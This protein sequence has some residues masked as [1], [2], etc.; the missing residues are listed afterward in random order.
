[1]LTAGIIAEYN[2]FHNGH[3]YHIQ[4]TKELH[5]AQRIIVVMSPSFTQRS[6]PAII[7]K[8]ARAKTALLCGADLVLELP[9]PYATASAEY[10][11]KNAVTILNSLGVTNI[12][13][14]GSE[15]G[16]I[17]NLEKA[18]DILD[19]GDFIHLLKAELKKGVSFASARK[20][21]A[22]KLC[23]E[24]E[25]QIFETPNNILAIEYLK[26]LKNL[27]SDITPVTV[28][29]E[30]TAYHENAIQG[31][32]VSATY[33]RKLI[34][35]NS[36]LLK[37]V[38]PEQSLNVLCEEINKG[39]CILS[40][41]SMELSM[42]TKLRTLTEEDIA[43]ISDTGEGLWRRIYKSIRE[44]CSLSEIA[45]LAKTK[46]YTMSRI[47]RILLRGFLGIKA[48]HV[49]TPAAYIRVLGFNDNGRELLRLADKKSALPVITKPSTINRLG[50]FANELFMLES[51]STDIW[52][53]HSEKISK[54]GLD[55][56]TNPV[57]IN[58]VSNYKG[59]CR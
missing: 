42:L 57:Y 16:N 2:P 22:A 54:C 7:S 5:G 33:C 41:S 59:W 10:F 13:S 39:S 45:A 14:F 4:K 32:F 48:Y 28:K 1:M 34:S 31:Q 27:G 43:G 47:K 49:T 26:A 3:L 29:R 56:T 50:D 8:W 12:L 53:T 24:T 21:A 25:A 46:R 37:N 35:E 30:G 40:E 58:N 15:S 23:G 51:M 19:S 9:L 17:E 36:P 6:E 38:L 52:Y 18:A 11:A 55:F 44:G 20:N